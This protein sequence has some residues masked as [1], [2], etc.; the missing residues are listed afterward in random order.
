MVLQVPLRSLQC[1]L[2]DRCSLSIAPA[3]TMQIALAVCTAL[4]CG[5]GEQTGLYSLLHSPLVAATFV[6]GI[7]FWDRLLF[8][9]GTT[10][11]W[12]YVSIAVVCF[13]MIISWIKQQMTISL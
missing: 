10:D 7:Y 3:L 11:D 5:W 1:S 12:G 13:V 9:C 8:V 4:T 2:F 6:F